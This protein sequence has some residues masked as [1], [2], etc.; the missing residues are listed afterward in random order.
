MEQELFEWKEWDQYDTMF[1]TFHNC[2]LRKDIG[3]FKVGD[4]M[5]CINVNYEDGVLEL[6]QDFDN[7]EDTITLRMRLEVY[8]AE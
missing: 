5:E 2:T 8:E 7:E 4:F 6:I 3:G 1:F